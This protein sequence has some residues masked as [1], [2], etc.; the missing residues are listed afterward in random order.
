MSDGTGCQCH[1]KVVALVDERETE[2][3]EIQQAPDVEPGAVFTRVAQTN[4]CG[5]ELHFWRDEFPFR[6]VLGHEALLVVEELGEGV[7]TDDAGEPLEVGDRVV[8]TYFTQC[9]TCPACQ[10]GQF[11]ACDAFEALGD[12]MQPPSMEPYYNGT[13]ATHYYVSPDQHIYKVPDNVPDGVAASANCA[14]SQ[15]LFAFDQANVRPGETVVIQ[16]A[17]GLGI[18]STAIAD[19][20]GATPIV[21]EG[22]PNRLERAKEFGAAHVVDLNEYETPGARESRVKALTDGAGAD[23]GVEVAGHPDVFAEGPALLRNGGRY[24][25]VGNISL[26]M[27]TEFNPSSLT[28]RN[29]TVH[30]VMLYQPWYLNRALEFLEA[31]VDDYPYET[32]LDAEFTLEEAQEALEKS[33]SRE[34]TRATLVP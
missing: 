20:M 1:G 6:G 18:H 12:W 13:F 30:A 5:S 22:A 19:A 24:I 16:G 21:I 27:H 7:D 9:G 2:V 25:E 15:M 31:H 34:I 33:D 23:V 8:A 11:Y 28:Y 4:V 14:L 10:R 29:L 17:G 26:D 32:L 3:Q